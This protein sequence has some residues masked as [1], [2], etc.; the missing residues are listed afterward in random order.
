VPGVSGTRALI[1]SARERGLSDEAVIGALDTAAGP[2]DG[3]SHSE[4][5]LPNRLWT[6]GVLITVRD[7]GHSH[8]LSYC[9][10]S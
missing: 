10:A 8:D 2:T 6:P 1:A 4:Q 3:S 9:G 7:E 5:E